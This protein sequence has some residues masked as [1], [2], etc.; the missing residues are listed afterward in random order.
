MTETS[1]PARNM[2]AMVDFHCFEKECPGIVKFSLLDAADKGFQTICPV[3]HRPYEF[4][5]EIVEKLRKLRELLLV[6]QGSVDILGDCKVAVTVPGGTVKIPY[7]LLLTRLNTLITLDNVD[8]HFRVEP[9]S[10]EVFR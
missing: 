10:T 6:I 4:T 5:G 9:G 1:T 8:F 2:V 7:P 3:C